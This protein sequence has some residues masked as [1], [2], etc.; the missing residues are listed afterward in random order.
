MQDTLPANNKRTFI[1]LL[2]LDPGK[3]RMIVMKNTLKITLLTVLSAIIFAFTSQAQ[4][5]EFTYQ[6]S[7]KD[8]GNPANATYDIEFLV[9]DAATGGSQIGATITKNAVTIT[10][11]IFAVKL[12]FGAVF[13][14]ANRF[15]E[16]HVRL[17]GQPSFTPLAPRQL[18]NSAPYS[19]KSLNTDNAATATNATQLGGIAANQYVLTGDARMSDARNPLPNSAN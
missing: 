10:N 8:S 13:P 6:G 4:V 2:E 17:T 16:I 18:V 5:T 9:F 14:G 15:L 12:D 19:V 7:L 11:G 1:D 3:V